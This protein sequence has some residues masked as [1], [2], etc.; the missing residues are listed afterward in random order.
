MNDVREGGDGKLYWG[1]L[2]AHAMRL[3]RAPLGDLAHPERLP[4]PLVT[5]YQ[6]DSGRLVFSQP[7]LPGLTLCRLDTL[8]CE[9]LG[10]DI[11]EVDVYHWQLAARSVYL[12]HRNGE[13]ARL[14]RFDIATRR[15]AQRFD[16]E[17]SG[18]GASIAV[19]PD[20]SRLLVAREEGPAIDLMIAR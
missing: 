5:N 13:D 15:I 2:S 6:I 16:F 4:T 17:P 3:M 18:A 11:S 12:R 9:P 8:A 10:L 20:E 19:S 1:E 14:A 7:S